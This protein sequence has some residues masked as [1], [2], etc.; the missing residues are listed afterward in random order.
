VQERVD[1][2]GISS[3]AGGHMQVVR[4]IQAGLSALGD[5]SLPILV[6]GVIPNADRP[7]LD[8]LGVVGV[9][10]PGSRPADIVEAVRKAALVP[11]EP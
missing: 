9:F 7:L 4:L 1:L 2:I 5:R 11:H 6:G 3:S 10:G 8:E